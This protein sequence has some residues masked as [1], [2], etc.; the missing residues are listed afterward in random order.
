MLLFAL[1]V[2]S[3]SKNEEPEIV[4]SRDINL[5]I[6]FGY[7]ASSRSYTDIDGDGTIQRFLILVYSKQDDG[8]YAF[9]KKLTILDF[10]PSGKVIIRVTPGEKRFY[11]FANYDKADI[12]DFSTGKKYNFD[13]AL[14][15]IR[16]ETVKNL[17]IRQF[18]MSDAK[19]TKDD[20]LPMTS[21][22]D[23]TVLDQDNQT[24]SGTV[25]MTRCIAKI[26]VSMKLKNSLSSSE[27]LSVKYLTIGNNP[28]Y[29]WLLPRENDK[30]Q[31]DLPSYNAGDYLTGMS[32]TPDTP[33]PITTSLKDIGSVYV[34]E[35]PY[36]TGPLR[37]GVK[38]ADHLA[39]DGYVGLPS[40]MTVFFTYYN[41]RE[42][43]DKG[44]LVDLPFICRNDHMS[45]VCTVTP[46]SSDSET[47]DIKVT[48]TGNW[49]QKVEDVP[50]YE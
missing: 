24:M 44:M 43:V 16:E 25:Y 31:V 14:D 20:L 22:R 6:S 15:N 13:L 30:G 38:E 45:I 17:V 40:R 41:G 37:N 8:S 2:A 49:T 21:I 42:S 26:S 10:D 12:V 4:S 32:Y 19:F 27:S 39:A 50:T 35:N 47:F 18:S 5:T 3:C 23:Y 7:L 1:C 29:S 33:T 46:P 48:V 9:E 11:F 36:G 34:H 28:S